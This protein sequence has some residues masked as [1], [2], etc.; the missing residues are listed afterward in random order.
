MLTFWN[1]SWS[2][3]EVSTLFSTTSWFKVGLTMQMVSKICEQK[4][5]MQ[6]PTL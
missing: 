5:T 2:S 3:S 6:A 1:A 4:N